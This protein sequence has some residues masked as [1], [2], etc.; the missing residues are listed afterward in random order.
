MKVLLPSQSKSGSGAKPGLSISE[1]GN[2]GK[3]KNASFL[4]ILRPK[5]GLKAK[6]ESANAATVASGQAAS[7]A[8]VSDGTLRQGPQKN[9]TAKLGKA[10]KS[11]SGKTV[12]HGGQAPKK[13]KKQSKDFSVLAVTIGHGIQQVVSKTN[14]IS[15]KKQSEIAPINLVK[16]PQSGQTKKGSQNQATVDSSTPG[17]SQ[18]DGAS[19][20][21]TPIRIANGFVSSLDQ[22]GAKKKADASLCLGNRKNLSAKPQ[23]VQ[24]AKKSTPQPITERN[25]VAQLPENASERIEGKRT[26][27][28]VV[29]QKV[30]DRATGI[31]SRKTISSDL[32][33]AN[34]AHKILVQGNSER[35]ATVVKGRITAGEAMVGVSASGHKVVKQTIA[36]KEVLQGRF[37][38]QPRSIQKAITT[39]VERSGS[40][41]NSD[42]SELAK[43]TRS[44]QLFNKTKGG[45]S[46][47]AQTKRIEKMESLGQV[48]K[49]NLVQSRLDET[50]AVP[51]ARGGAESVNLGVDDKKTAYKKDTPVVQH[52]LRL[53][54]VASVHPPEL[55]IYGE[56]NKYNP[57]GKTSDQPLATRGETVHLSRERILKTRMPSVPNAPDNLK[58]SIRQINVSRV[59]E[60]IAE[61]LSNPIR[62]LTGLQTVAA[63]K[64]TFILR[65]IN[66]E[67]ASAVTGK[68]SQR[69]RELART[70]S[71]KKP[72]KPLMPQSK[73]DKEAFKT[74]TGGMED[75][76]LKS[77][78]NLARK[79]AQTGDLRQNLPFG[80]Q[81]ASRGV[82]KHASVGVEMI[83]AGRSD[84]SHIRDVTF[85]NDFSNR[86]NQA[87]VELQS[88][89][90]KAT[91]SKA[92]P[93]VNAIMY[94]QVMSAVETFRAMNTGRW[95]M[96]IEPFNNLRMQ[97]D[98]RMS[99]ARLVVQ[100]KLERGSQAVIGNGWSDLQASLAEKDVDLRSLI[101]ATQKEGHSNMF[102]GKNERQSGGAKQDDETWFSEELTELL[103]EFE[104]DAQKQG[105]AKRN[106]RKARMPEA[107][108]ESWA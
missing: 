2:V 98:L 43:P 81:S 70:A 89:Q 66:R 106:G 14:A 67:K 59:Q 11:L 77:D 21:K 83:E 101:T 8:V 62:Q 73:V 12:P 108:F 10:T 56:K 31:D 36:T 76:F 82:K 25:P 53:G 47:N 19:Q 33:A 58:E 32:G 91:Q 69:L 9:P 104:K 54:K 6:A 90:A 65:G 13:T 103:A 87:D 15:L 3:S 30:A 79:M 7:K 38:N 23:I 28:A 24:R 102:G 72:A 49:G 20:Q 60:P 39:P 57:I 22:K 95:A 16:A 55:E 64:S 50:S 96:T 92:Q 84:L 17:A 26:S 41:G 46:Q 48:T 75:A 61:T 93:P 27:V 107:T 29:A 94:R 5:V 52:P 86:L 85:R 74:L 105:K 80:G 78:M 18:K 100:A 97:L 37:A 1:Q 71:S 45:R 63:A 35:I 51:T 4:Q 88:L 34:K 44:Q 68:L 99:D 40:Y 42:L